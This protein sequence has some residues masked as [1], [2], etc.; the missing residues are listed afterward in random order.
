MDLSVPALSEHLRT[1]R[2]VSSSLAAGLGLDVDQL[3]DLRI[4]ID[5]LCSMLIEHAP[6]GVVLRLTL[7]AD[8]E[9]H[10]VADGSLLQAAPASTIDPIS[11][12]ILDGLDVEWST[13][14]PPP[15]FRLVAPGR[16]RRAGF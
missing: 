11:R 9:G 1:L 15:S 6:P 10:L 13:D 4:A 8:E 16:Q 7:C 12:L 14:G 2:L 5:E 3:D